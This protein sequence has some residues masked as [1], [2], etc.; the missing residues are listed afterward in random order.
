MSSE[1]GTNDNSFQFGLGEASGKRE[2]FS[3]GLKDLGQGR[4]NM[5]KDNE[6]EWRVHV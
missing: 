6:Q 3:R 1:S 5:N 4:E 2:L